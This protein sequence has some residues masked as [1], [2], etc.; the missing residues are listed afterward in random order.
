[1]EMLI[2]IMNTHL[3]LL[4]LSVRGYSTKSEKKKVPSNLNV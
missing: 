2:N 3:I 1:M 4:I